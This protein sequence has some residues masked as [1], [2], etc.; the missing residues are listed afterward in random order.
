[1]R[2]SLISF[3]AEAG[4]RDGHVTGVQTC[5][6]PILLFSVDFHSPLIQR[7]QRDGLIKGEWKSTENNR[8]AKY[9][10][11]TDQGRKKIGRAS[12]RER[13]EIAG[14]A[15]SRER[16]RRKTGSNALRIERR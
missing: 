9:Y 14:V 7:L 8:R 6:L 5:A 3:Q 1:M 16:K 15:A 2:S 11:L 13:G 12:C 4:I 10:M